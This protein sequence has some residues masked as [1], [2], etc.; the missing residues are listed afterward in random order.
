MPI[1]TTFIQHSTESLGQSN[2]AW[3]RIKGD[4][5]LKR[6][7]ESPKTQSKKLLGQIK[8]FSRAE[9]YKTNIQKWGAFLSIAN[10]LKSR[11]KSYL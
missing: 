6:E 9:I 5:I 1:S 3:E 10:S 8:E 2:Q 11:K 7:R 4:T